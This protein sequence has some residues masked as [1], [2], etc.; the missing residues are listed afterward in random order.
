[1]ESSSVSPYEIDEGSYN[2]YGT[3][4]CVVGNWFS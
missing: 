4:F 1:L 2:S 3:H